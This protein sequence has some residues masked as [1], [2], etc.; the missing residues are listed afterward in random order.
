MK[1]QIVDC[2]S[3]VVV[4]LVVVFLVIGSARTQK[5]K[6]QNDSIYYVTNQ[7]YDSI[8]NSTNTDKIWFYVKEVITTNKVD[9]Q[10]FYIGNKFIE[11]GTRSDGVIVWR[12]HITK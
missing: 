3:I 2:L 12:E 5:V 4:F 6:W 10:Y 7:V 8:R 11:L 9:P 1:K